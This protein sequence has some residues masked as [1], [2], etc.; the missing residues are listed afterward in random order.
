GLAAVLAPA[1]LRPEWRD[2]W[3]S[4][5]EAWWIFNRDLPGARLGLLRE[6][7]AA[8]PDAF[9]RSQDREEAPRRLHLALGSPLFIGGVLLCIL[10]AIAWLSG[11]FRETQAML[12]EENGGNPRLV[13]LSNHSPFL[14]LASGVAS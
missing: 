2:H 7:L 8:V 10:G 14:G 13:I 12:S 9:W 1:Q 3:Q 6:T 11:G 5:S 4:K